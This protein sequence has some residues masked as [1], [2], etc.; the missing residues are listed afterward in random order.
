[1][2]QQ[3]EA[4]TASE[5]AIAK[6]RKP[7]AKKDNFLASDYSS[8]QDIVLSEVSQSTPKPDFLRSKMRIIGSRMADRLRT[9]MNAAFLQGFGSDLAN[10]NIYHVS[11]TR[12][13]IDDRAQLLIK[14][15]THDIEMML[16]QRIDTS[17]S[18]DRISIV[19]T[20]FEAF[21]YR[22]DFIS[23]TEI[24]RANNLGKIY[25]AIYGGATKGQYLI[26]NE[27]CDTCKEHAKTPVHFEHYSLETVPPHHPGCTCGLT[28][29]EV[30]NNG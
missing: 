19:R 29:T 20:I 5:K 13:E 16:N 26:Q 4:Q 12:R 7:L 17:S 2:G 14:R 30:K 1:L 28:I 8:L 27:T 11:R 18:D 23:K 10:Q 3:Q 24:A 6:A 21:R 22:T 15:L 9:N 25:R